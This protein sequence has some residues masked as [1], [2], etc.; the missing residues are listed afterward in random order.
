MDVPRQKNGA[1][2]AGIQYRG[3][4][5]P[6]SVGELLPV[7]R[8]VTVRNACLGEDLKTVYHDVNASV[9]RDNGP[10]EPL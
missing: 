10:L 4:E 8:E 9:A 3:E 2:S 6:L 7:L 1:A 5:L